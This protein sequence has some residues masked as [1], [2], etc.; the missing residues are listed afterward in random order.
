MNDK[1]DYKDPAFPD[2]G[3]RAEQAEEAPSKEPTTA[4]KK[5][6][7]LLI[8]GR[9]ILA[10]G[11]LTAILAFIGWGVSSSEN[12]LGEMETTVHWITGL[13]AALGAFLPS[14]FGWGVLRGL[15][16]IKTEV[17]KEGE[18]MTKAE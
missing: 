5:T 18:S 6:D 9:F 7:A 13:V 4:G 3:E 12:V 11:V 16:D 14:L 10:F 1:G 8:A 2:E 17:V 15:V